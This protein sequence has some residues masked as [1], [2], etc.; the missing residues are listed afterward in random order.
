MLVRARRC[1]LAVTRMAMG[2]AVGV[3]LRTVCRGLRWLR[4]QPLMMRARVQTEPFAHRAEHEGERP[5]QGEGA[6][7][8]QAPVRASRKEWSP[9]H[10]PKLMTAPRCNKHPDR[11]PTQVSEYP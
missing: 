8:Q 3:M 4:S 11:S 5:E 10:A 6:A 9:V 7:A 2:S 1:V